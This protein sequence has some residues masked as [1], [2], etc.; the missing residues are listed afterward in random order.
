[1]KL[2][3]DV[4]TLIAL[5]AIVNPVTAIPVFVALAAGMTSRERRRLALRTSLVTGITLVVAYF[6]GDVI[7]KS[8]SIQLD[9]FRIAGAAVIAAFGWKMAM[10]KAFDKTS[11]EAGGAT[12]GAAI[13]PLA[14]PLMAGPGAIATVI[15]L[16]NSEVGVARWANLLIIIALTA[17]TFLFLLAAAPIERLVGD[18]G[19]MVISRIL[20][21]LL[22]AIAA[23]TVLVAL[24][25]SFPALTVAG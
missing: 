17:L 8:L 9:A 23:S 25:S 24:G 20:G 3:S 14:I 5:F 10:G 1:M 21:L 7:L 13:V 4:T 12:S 19:L 11:G 15:A 16:G 22:L 2:N 18:T 6:L